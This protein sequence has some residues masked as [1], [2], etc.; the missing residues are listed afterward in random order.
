MKKY[1]NY[2]IGFGIL[3][4][5]ILLGNIFSGGNNN[6][7]QNK[8]EHSYI[9][10]PVTKKWT[11]SMHPQ[12][13]LDKPGS[14]PICGM[15]LIAL[16]QSNGGDNISANEVVMTEEAIQLANIQTSEVVKS[17][18]LK[19]IRLLG[20]VKPDERRLFSQ[21]S[22]IP[23][24]IER[25]YVNFTGE[26]I[27]KGQKIAR[28]YSPELISAQKELFEAIKSKEIY[29]QLYKASR[30]KLRLWKLSD[31]QI[32]DI[33]NSGKVQ[34]QIDI[35]SDY[36]GYVMQRKIEL[37]DHVMEGMKLFDIANI[38]NVWIMFEAYEVDIPWISRGDDIEFNITA[39]PEKTFKGKVTYIDPF[40]SADA[41]VAKVRVEVKNSGHKLLPGMY[42]NG[43]IRAKLNKLNDA[44]IIPKSAVLWTGKRSVV[45]VKVPHENTISFIYRE[46]I[47]G[48]DLGDFY[49]VKK[50]LEEREKVAT[51]GVFR[52]DAS[53]QLLGKKSMMN[54]DG[55]KISIGGHAGMDMGDDKKEDVE[56]K[57]KGRSSKLDE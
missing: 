12:I 43:I 18:A 33:V 42:A 53:A 30:N 49:I 27:R 52:I 36:S 11:C 3:I 44:L 7:Q 8:E 17:D 6:S 24:R 55:G 40:V 51:N 31:A 39:I 29:P 25:L 35:L 32:E 48:A 10:D 46:I 37:G 14:C 22:H 56:K 54:P 13:I 16:D 34:E 5:G 9:Q 38:D 21:V 1:K 23:G 50:G 28:I 4:I 41:R 26:K 45:Y 19:E 2:I 15:D 47:L 57:D 20:V